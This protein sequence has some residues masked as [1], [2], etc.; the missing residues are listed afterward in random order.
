MLMSY[1]IIE[2]S[3]KLTSFIE[4]YWLVQPNQDGTPVQLRVDVYPDARA[5]LILN[6]GA[7]YL[8]TTPEATTEYQDSNLDAQRT[9]P[10][11]IH[12]KGE[13]EIVGVRFRVGGLGAFVGIP[14]ARFTD[15][16]P[17]LEEVFGSDG[18]ELNTEIRKAFPALDKVGELLDQFFLE[19][20]E[21]SPEYEH[22]RIMLEQVVSSQSPMFAAEV[23]RASGISQRTV[24]RYFS[25]FLGLTVNKAQQIT[26]FQSSLKY[27]MSGPQGSLAQ[28]SSD[29]GYFDQ[30]HFIRDFKKFAGGIPGE[31]RHY[32]PECA[33]RDFA[34]NLVQFVQD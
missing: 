16:T 1:R 29:C 31:F 9:Y 15:C 18:L 24:S 5:D 7:P 28:V 25:R 12:Q 21:L 30:S 23:G 33:P 17:S 32:F 27:L 14:L 8:R 13:V 26:R 4:S 11:V 2:P 34:P 10:I 19:R 20:L 6:F 3:P 22:F